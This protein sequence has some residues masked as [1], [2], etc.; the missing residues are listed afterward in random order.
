MQT[1][2]SST[3]DKFGLIAATITIV[4]WASA[5]AGIRVALE[6]YSPYSLALLRYFIASV[7]LAIYMAVRGFRCRTGATS[8]VLWGWASSA[9][10][11]TTSR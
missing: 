7:A 11:S 8:P 5:F 3:P 9:L 10:A 4:L 1:Q 2:S 6:D